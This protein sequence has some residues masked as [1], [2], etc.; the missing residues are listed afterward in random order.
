MSI[1]KARLDGKI[2][3]AAES[4]R[5]RSDFR[6]IQCGCK[7]KLKKFPAPRTDYYYARCSGEEHGKRTCSKIENDQGAAIITDDPDKWGERMATPSKKRGKTTKGIDTLG[8][9]HV[10]I[11]AD[12]EPDKLKITKI[13]SLKQL[14][15]NGIYDEDPYDSVF[16][17]SKF[18]NIDY[19]IV[20]KW[21]K[22]FWVEPY[23]PVLRWR[24][25][26][27]RW[28]GS[29]NFS[30]N[31]KR[32]LNKSLGIDKCIWF[33]MY[34]KTSSENYKNVRFCLDCTSCLS[35]I[36]KKIFK[37][38]MDEESGKFIEIIE[39]E[40]LVLA[41]WAVMDRSQ[42]ESH[43]ALYDS[44]KSK[45]VGCKGAYWGKCNTAKQVE[46]FPTNSDTK[47]KKDE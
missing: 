19:V 26:D 24:A 13:T 12:P 18:R 28:L 11:E 42:C 33:T 43:C 14:I 9:D 21:A 36:K 10:G 27:V 29:F 3:W 15:N 8:V 25:V 44:K 6:C 40:V 41:N 23:L 2:V 17:D 30:D 35:E 16:P 34:W 37:S 38:A 31:I 4:L 47:D 46:L 39:S 32:K 22:D 1:Q 5:G 7:L 45:C 20:S